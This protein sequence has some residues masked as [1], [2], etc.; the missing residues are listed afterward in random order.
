VADTTNTRPTLTLTLTRG[1]ILDNANST[2]HS[3]LLRTCH[4]TNG[5]PQK[6]TKSVWFYYY[7]Y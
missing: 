3:A 6:C 4:T 1:I 7:Y 5:N 2:A